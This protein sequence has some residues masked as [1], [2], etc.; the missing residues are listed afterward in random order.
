MIWFF[1][2][3]MIAGAVGWHMLAIYIGRKLKEK[4]MQKAFKK[5]ENTHE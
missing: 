2:M 3:G 5:E 4:E 1:L